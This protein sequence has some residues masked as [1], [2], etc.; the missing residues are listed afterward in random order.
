MEFTEYQINVL[1]N[2]IECRI[3]EVEEAI[4][5]YEDREEEKELYESYRKELTELKGLLSFFEGGLT[6]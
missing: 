3:E 5:Q 1:L 2:A 4:I 6:S